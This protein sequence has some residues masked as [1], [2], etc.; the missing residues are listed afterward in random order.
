MKPPPHPTPPPAPKNIPAEVVAAQRAIIGTLAACE[1]RFAE[2]YAQYANAFPGTRD[3]W[4]CLSNEEIGHAAMLE[5]MK[6]FLDA[7]DYFT[8]IGALAKGAESAI[9][10]LDLE[11][12]MVKN[13][14]VTEPEAFNHAMGFES[15]LVDGHFYEVV[16]CGANEFQ[17]MASVLRKGAELHRDKIRDRMV[18][19]RAELRDAWKG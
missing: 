1:R 15:R 3:F 4:T 16:N 11:I 8:N 13:G 12:S 14:F 10:D 7:G 6:R 2:V 17:H 18:G 19:R 9:K 5:S